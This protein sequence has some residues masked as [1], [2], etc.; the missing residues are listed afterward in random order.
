M[1]H[2]RELAGP[3][4]EQQLGLGTGWLDDDHPGR[5]AAARRGDHDI[6]GSDSVIHRLALRPRRS[7]GDWPPVITG[8]HPV[9]TIGV[10]Q[11]SGKYIHRRRANELCNKQ[12][13]GLVEQFE[14]RPYLLDDSVVHHH[15]SIGQGHGFYLVMG[16]IHG[17]GF[18]ALVQRLDLRAHR[19]A[20]L[21]IQVGQRFVEQED[22]GI[23]NNRATH[24]HTLALTARQLARVTV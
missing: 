21:G 3:D 20:Q 12:A 13:A 2:H 14:W 6:A 11:L 8:L 10:M 1:Q 22:L 18:E 5:D 16:H 17:G 7:G 23:S 15:D 19:H 9:L 24:G 4:L